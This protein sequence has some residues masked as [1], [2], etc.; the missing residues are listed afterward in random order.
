MTLFNYCL[1]AIDLLLMA[2]IVSDYL[3][4]VR[5]KQHN[6]ILRGMLTKKLALRAVQRTRKDDLS[7]HINTLK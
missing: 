3:D 1:L 7:N 6:R 5:V 4:I 2:K